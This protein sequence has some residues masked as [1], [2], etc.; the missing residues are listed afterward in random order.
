MLSTLLAQTSV[1]T[2]TDLESGLAAGFSLIWL[3]I[4]VAFYVFIAL[5][6]NKMLEKANHPN[7]WAGWVP[8]YNFWTVCEIAG[9]PGWW[10]LV[11]LIGGIPFVNILVFVVMVIVSIDLS[12]SFGKGG[13]F[14]AL[15]VLLPVVGYPMLGF[16]DAQYQGPAGPEGDAFR[17]NNVNG[18]NQTP[19]SDGNGP[20]APTPPT[21]PTV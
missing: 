11:S 1:T 6:I 7:N 10:S 15:L 18:Q 13:G 19:P 21:S 14:A 9:R 8:V 3:I 17:G 5:S 4:F 20:Q 16:G 2:T 12:K